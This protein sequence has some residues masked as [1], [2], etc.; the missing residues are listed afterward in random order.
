MNPHDA[1]IQIYNLSH[2]WNHHSILAHI[3]SSYMRKLSDLLIQNSHQRQGTLH[4]S[5]GPHQV[6][7]MDTPATIAV[8]R[9]FS[10]KR[11]PTSMGAAAGGQTAFKLP[12]FWLHLLYI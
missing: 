6:V 1:S 8:P 12:I 11:S 10:T 9:R 7:A 4:G 3:M 5:A 2:A